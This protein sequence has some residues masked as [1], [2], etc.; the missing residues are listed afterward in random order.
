M[1]AKHILV[2]N[3]D[4]IGFPGLKALE[5]SLHDLGAVTVVA[6]ER[7]MSGTSQ[8]ITI[9]SPLRINKLDERHY[10]VSGT[11]A[12]AVILALHKLLP[13]KPAL[14]ASGINPGW[15]LGENVIYS[16]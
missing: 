7:E 10:S 3:D 4:G 1:A 8:G 12:D 16:G 14:V 15:N 11:P 9:Y 2:T 6:P 13:Q 5:E